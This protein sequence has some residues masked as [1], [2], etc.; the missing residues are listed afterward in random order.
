MIVYTDDTGREYF[1]AHGCTFNGWATFCRTPGVLGRKLV[2]CRALP[3]RATCEEAQA[4]LDAY[5]VKK[6]WKTYVEDK[7]A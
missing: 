1:V 2:R 7:D 4:D 6:G 5:A 3:V